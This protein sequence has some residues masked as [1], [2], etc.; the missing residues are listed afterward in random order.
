MK[1]I[2]T[3]LPEVLVIEPEVYADGRGFFLEIYHAEK[4]RQAGI[5]HPWAQDNHSRSVRGTLRGLH[6]QRRRPQAK[7]VRAVQGEIYDVAVD[8]RRGSPRFGRWTATVL[9]NDNLRLMYIPVGFAHGFCV[10]SDWAEVEYKA[11]D[12]YDP[13]DEIR[14]LWNDPAL[15]VVWPVSHPLLS[16]KDRN[17][18]LLAECGDRL[19]DFRPG[20]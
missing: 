2:P 9:S 13:T 1:F 6:A 20:P 19:F 7:L 11:S 17:G 18:C 14:I 5:T 12:L 8:I 15:G 4:Y 3:D 16:E 10:L